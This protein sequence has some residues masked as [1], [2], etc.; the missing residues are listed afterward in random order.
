MLTST[1]PDYAFDLVAKELGDP[2]LL[3]MDIAPSKWHPI[4]IVRSPDMA[5]AFTKATQ[6]HP[7]SSE[8][9][10]TVGELHIMTG[11]LSIVSAE[12]CHNS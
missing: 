1:N 3:M 12:V 11:R 9:A 8:K 10:Y 5:E 4:C 2:P 7:Y 6:S